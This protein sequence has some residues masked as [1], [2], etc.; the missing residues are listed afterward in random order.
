MCEVHKYA[1]TIARPPYLLCQADLPV[2]VHVAHKADC[3][4]DR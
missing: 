4:F 3:S 2:D 1:A